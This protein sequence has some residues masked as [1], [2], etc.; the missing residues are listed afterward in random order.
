MA[1]AALTAERTR[2]GP[3]PPRQSVPTSKITN[4]VALLQ[5]PLGMRKARND[6][7]AS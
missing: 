2:S 4:G 7:E 6:C 3:P 5:I 1:A